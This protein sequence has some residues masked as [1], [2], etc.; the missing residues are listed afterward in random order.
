MKSKLFGSSGSRGLVNVDLTPVLVAKIGM[1]IATFSR[2]KRILVARDTRAS[3]LMLE[4]ALVSSLL[5]CGVDV[6]CLGVLPTPVLA[7]L[8]REVKADVGVMITASHNPPQYNGVKIFDGSGMAYTAENQRK[9]EE[10]VKNEN[11]RLADWRSIGKVHAIDVCQLYVEMMRKAVKLHRKWHVVVDPGCG[12]THALAPMIFKALGCRVSAINA[13]PDGFFTARSP[14]PNAKSLKPLA[15]VIQEFGADV[16]VAYDGDGDRVAFIDERGH[17]VDFDR[18]LAAYAAYVVRKVGGGCVV[19]NVEASMGVEKMVKAAG[20]RVVRTSVG[21]V[22]IAEAIRRHNA[23]FGGEPCGAWIHPKFH[24][25]PDGLLSSVLFLKALEDE[26][27]KPSEFTAEVPRYSI[28]RENV[29]CRNEIKQ[30]VME[31]VEQALKL[32]FPKY[33]ECLK[34]DGIRLS[35][36]GGWILV[37]ASGTEPLVRLT[38]EG[39]SVELAREIMEKG[40]SLVKKLAEEVEK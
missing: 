20:G 26:G 4:D 36:R 32:A 3:G 1:A 21:D 17:F 2:A 11:F 13:H 23:L 27:L 40:M 14:E 37:R 31:K 28:L 10:I 16:G 8:T 7:Y 19:T 22:H 15:R 39:E 12:A 34:I 5:A 9:I 6:D 33:K 38:V 30:K 35:L 29:T 25:C 18:V 24:Y